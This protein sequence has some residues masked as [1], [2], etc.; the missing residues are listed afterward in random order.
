MTSLLTVGSNTI[1]AD[2]TGSS[3]DN[4]STSSSLIQVVQPISALTYLVGSPNPAALGQAVTLTATVSPMGDT[5]TPAGSIT[6]ADQFGTLGTLPLAGSTA[7]LTVSSLTTGTHNIVATFNATGNFAGAVSTV[8]PE[9]IQS[10]D[11][12]VT[13]NPASL[14]LAAGMQGQVMVQLAGVGNLPGN[15]SLQ[16]DQVPLYATLGFSPQIV[17]FAAGG[18][19]FSILTIDTVQIPRRA[20]L[21]IPGYRNK[22]LVFAFTGLFGIPLLLLRRRRFLQSLCSLLLVTGVV[23]LSGCTDIYS[24]VN[25]VAPGTYSI[26][27]TATDA[28][29]H[30]THTATLILTV[31]P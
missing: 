3:S 19:V 7:V 6:F 8:Y 13:L 1:F 30:I 26:P 27:I 9:L 29:T 25:R 18:S 23:T 22:H 15:I 31:V 17:A 21:E 12:S 14:S 4:S 28:T 5:A 16:A 20:L 24:P 2:Y 10:F 11:F